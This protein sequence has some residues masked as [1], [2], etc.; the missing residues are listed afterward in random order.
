MSFPI[1][2]IGVIGALTLLSITAA[3]GFAYVAQK[4]D[5]QAAERDE[6]PCPS[7]SAEIHIRNTQQLAEFWDE[8]LRCSASLHTSLSWEGSRLMTLNPAEAL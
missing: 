4:T 5:R 1:R 6:P 2:E 8:S 7:L 3:D